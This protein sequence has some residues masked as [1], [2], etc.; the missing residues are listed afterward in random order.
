MEK[1]SQLQNKKNLL[2]NMETAM[3][4]YQNMYWAF[5]NAEYEKEVQIKDLGAKIEALK[6]EIEE[7]DKK[8]LESKKK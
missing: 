3:S 2:K 6:K 4:A 8:E 5:R 1:Q 7:E